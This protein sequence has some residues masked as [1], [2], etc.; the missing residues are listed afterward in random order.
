[1]FC[2]VRSLPCTT[3]A[4]LFHHAA[5]HGVCELCRFFA[6]LKFAIDVVICIFCSGLGYRDF[7]VAKRLWKAQFGNYWLTAAALICLGNLNIAIRTWPVRQHS[8]KAAVNPA[9]IGSESNS[10]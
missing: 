9:G 3:S 8:G 5:L 4:Y 10:S 7:V 6:S 1:M 2:F